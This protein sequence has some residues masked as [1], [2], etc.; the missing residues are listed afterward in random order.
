MY[1]K[2]GPLILGR[3][4][5]SYWG[6][7]HQVG[8]KASGS[9]PTSKVQAQEGACKRKT[10]KGIESFQSNSFSFPVC[11]NSFQFVYF[12]YRLV[13]T[14]QISQVPRGPPSPPPPVHHSPPRKLTAKEMTWTES[15]D[16]RPD[17]T[18]QI[19]CSFFVF[20]S[21]F[22]FNFQDRFLLSQHWTCTL[23]FF[24]SYILPGPKGLEDSSVHLQL[25]ECKGRVKEEWVHTDFILM[26]HM[27]WSEVYCLSLMPEQS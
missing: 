19:S 14:Y 1:H 12:V 2:P 27:M 16:Q 20:L 17:M 13:K 6:A 3:C 9:I 8:R 10:R 24:I 18:W 7:C 11:S 25:E 23:A 5:N 22:S 4:H 15:T 26:W 21:K